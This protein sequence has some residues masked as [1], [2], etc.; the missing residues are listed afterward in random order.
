M[1]SSPVYT[2]GC[3]GEGVNTTAYFRIAFAA[4]ASASDA[5]EPDLAMSLNNL[6]NRYDALGQEEEAEEARKKAQA[7]EE[8]RSGK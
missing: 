5:F 1:R 2:V 4:K 6:G 3:P 8:R 7:I